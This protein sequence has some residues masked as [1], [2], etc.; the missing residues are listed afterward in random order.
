MR[1]KG[2]GYEMIWFDFR[3]RGKLSWIDYLTQWAQSAST[4]ALVPLA[5]R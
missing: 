5:S 3:A 1:S 2:E 4:D